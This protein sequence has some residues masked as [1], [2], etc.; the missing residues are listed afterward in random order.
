MLNF[1]GK[2]GSMIFNFFGEEKKSVF[3]QTAGNRERNV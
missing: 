1:L 2:G 3:G